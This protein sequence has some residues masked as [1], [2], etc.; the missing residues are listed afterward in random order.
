MRRRH[1]QV[2]IEVSATRHEIAVFENGVLLGH[3]SVQRSSGETEAEWA[4][5][6]LALEAE[7][8]AWVAEF[9]IAG[10]QTTVVYSGPDTAV[11]VH[12]CPVKAGESRAKLAAKIAVS[13]TISYPIDQNAH[14]EFCVFKDSSVP[15]GEEPKFRTLALVDTDATIM[16]LSLMLE[17]A[18][19]CPTSF[20]PAQG[21]SLAAAVKMFA[22]HMAADGARIVLWIG[23][24]SSVIVAGVG[25]RI[26]LAR[27]VPV[28]TETFVE[29]LARPVGTGEGR[30]AP[31]MNR[32]VACELLFTSG[33]PI[34]DGG[35]ASSAS[36]DVR[37]VLPLVQPSL[38]RLIVELK[39]SIRFGLDSGVRK[40]ATLLIRGPGSQIPGLKEAI[41]SGVGL[42]TDEPSSENH[43]PIEGIHGDIAAVLALGSRIPALVTREFATQRVVNTTRRALWM[44][45]AMALLAIG[46][47]VSDSLSRSSA[48]RQSLEQAAS[49]TAPLISM[50]D[51]KVQVAVAARH[52]LNHAKA[53][54]RALLGSTP[55]YGAVLA[56]LSALTPEEVSLTEIAFAKEGDSAKCTIRGWAVADDE[57]TET[58]RF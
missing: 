42:N 12:D 27:L 26:A 16:S 19:L 46:A 7:V 57:M 31:L 8:T 22:E 37:A 21:A 39:Q 11:L 13:G 10:W 49:E 56:A 45:A 4:E 48:A 29:A 32:E 35:D 25:E 1:K 9:D 20:V 41:V 55:L 50:A 58:D 33:I 43:S 2:I 34:P 40:H 54:E 28:G 15:E 17:R 23:E 3:R 44:G 24:H 6:I 53:R 18:G 38:Q 14:G 51:Q 5:G 52:G 30:V 47:D 36:F